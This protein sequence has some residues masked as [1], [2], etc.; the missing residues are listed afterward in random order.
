MYAG[1]RRHPARLIPALIA[2][3][4]LLTACGAGADA[5]KSDQP[6][7]KV[8][9]TPAAGNTSAKL[10]SEISVRADGGKLTSVEVKDDKGGTV[11]GRLAGDG[12]SWNSDGKV[13]PQ[14]TYT[15]QT[16]TKSTQGK[17]SSA[18]S[19]FTTERADK[20]NK[21][22]NTPGGGQT[23]GTGMPVSILFDHPVA[24]DRRADIEKALKVT[25]QPKVAGR[26]GLGQG[27]LRQGP[28]RLASQ[29]LLAVRHQGLRQERTV[30]YQLR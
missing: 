10:G 14:T 24:K 29:D 13:K 8:T 9:V 15:V 25:T 28:D 4:T 7:A 23:V 16:K 5:S 21:L 19:K 17:E 6:A 30:R 22:T 27:L 2:A 11:A 18:T 3:G 1:S 26:L 20:V 12:A